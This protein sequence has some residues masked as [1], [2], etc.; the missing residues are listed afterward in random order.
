MRGGVRWASAPQK[1]F[2]VVLQFDGLD[3]R[4][5]YVKE[6]FFVCFRRIPGGFC[7]VLH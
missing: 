3:E 1:M 4:A 6:V 7:V 2:H 5:G